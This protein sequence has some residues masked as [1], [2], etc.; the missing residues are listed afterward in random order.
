MPLQKSLNYLTLLIFGPLLILIGILG[1]IMTAQPT[2]TAP[3][4]NIF[5]LFFGVIGIIL[6]LLKKEP[7]MAAFNIGF[8][9]IDLY[10]AVASFAGIFPQQLF[11]WTVVD[12]VLHVIIGA[13]LVLIGLYGRYVGTFRS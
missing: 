8:G 4:Y 12:D 7:L 6:L 3:A 11:Q 2:S 5:H 13:G 1:F 10:Q 9:A